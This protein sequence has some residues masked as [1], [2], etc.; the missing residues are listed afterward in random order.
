MYL[1]ISTIIKYIQSEL[2]LSLLLLS[3]IF[4]ISLK[5]NLL[6]TKIVRGKSSHH[7][8]PLVTHLTT[9][10]KKSKIYINSILSDSQLIK[11]TC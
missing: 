3:S 6:S 8:K 10:H 5:D 11:Y 4:T 9:N 2:L 1:I 7:F